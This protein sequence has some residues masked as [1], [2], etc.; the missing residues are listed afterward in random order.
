MIESMSEIRNLQ[1]NVEKTE[2]RYHSVDKLKFLCAFLIVCIHAPF[3]G[4]VGEYFKAVARIAVPVFF[5]ISGFFWTHMNG[6]KQI[7][8]LLKLMAV[9][10]ILYFSISFAKAIAVGGTISFLKTT[11]TVK[12]ILEFIIM[13]NSPFA[14]HLWYLGA[15][16]YVIVVVWIAEQN[17]QKRILLYAAPILMICDLLLGKYSLA[18]FHREF[19]YTIVRNWLF[20][21]IPYFMVGNYINE[22][23]NW[24]K[25]RIH[26]SVIF[27][28]VLFF[29]LAS[30]LERYFLVVA[31]LNTKRDH[32]IS[33]TFLAIAVFLA[34]L[35]YIDNHKSLV[36]QIGQK[37]STWIYI[38]HYLLISVCNF[39]ASTVHATDIY[40]IAK[41]III[42]LTTIIA[43]ELA[44]KILKVFMLK[45]RTI[46]DK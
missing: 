14:P 4:E 33:T 21:G 9:A 25:E 15:I 7:I 44:R 24:I 45:R 35:F 39:I 1:N 8:K 43:I 16:I 12:K 28:T 41:P 36:A 23:R 32:Y 37:A 19:P 40:N 34:F 29:S 13:N 38:L 2:E 5:M 31:G 6:K 17:G 10:N 46:I 26:Q 22:K 20:V 3:P 42:F 18:I 11:F 30:V 27:G